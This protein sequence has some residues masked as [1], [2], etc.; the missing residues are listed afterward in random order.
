VTRRWIGAFAL[1][2][3][4]D[5]PCPAANEP[6]A[7]DVP[8]SG[9]TVDALVAAF[10]AQP[11]ASVPLTWRDGAQTTATASIAVVPGTGTRVQRADCLTEC[12]TSYHLAMA[13][14][15]DELYVDARGTASTADGRVV[16]AEWTG[17]VAVTALGG[18]LQ[19]GTSPDPIPEAELKGTLDLVQVGELEP[20]D[21]D[22]GLRVFLY[23]VEGRLTSMSFDVERTSGR[24]D[25]ESSGVSALGSTE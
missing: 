5:R 18:E 1:V 9:A 17:S 22:L 15:P 3:C 24:G 16:D 6:R 23:G 7:D 11:F 8:V 12:R 13:C 2:G 21:R 10:A 4:A 14:G 25:L 20:D 19:W